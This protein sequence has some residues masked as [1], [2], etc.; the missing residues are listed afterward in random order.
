MQ[1]DKSK[2][3]AMATLVMGIHTSIIY[4]VTSC[5]DPKELWDTLKSQFE[6]NTLANKLFL[7]RQFFTT[8]M[9]EDQRVRDHLKSMKEISDKLAAL[10]AAVPEEEKVV[11]LLISLPKSY[12]TLVT[13]LE[14][15]GD[16]VTLAFVEQALVTEEQKRGV[17]KAA[18]KDVGD[19]ALRA[20]KGRKPFKFRCYKCRKEGHKAAECHG[21]SSRPQEQRRSAFD[22]KAADDEEENGSHMFM[23][24]TG[25]M[26][27]ENNHTWILDSGAS[28]HMT[29][30]RKLLR[31]YHQ[32][33]VPQ[34]VRLGDGRTVEA[35]G[36]GHVRITV[37]TGQ[38]KQLTTEMS[39]VLYVP[40]LACNLFSVRAVTQKGLVVQFG[41]T[42]CWIKTSSGK[43]IGKGRLDNRMYQLS[44]KCEATDAEGDQAQPAVEGPSLTLWHQ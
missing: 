42:C 6:R 35:Y 36:S 17:E 3:K 21:K 22:A 27:G 38:G 30:D 14:A 2:Q 44:C 41:H 25:Q 9:S 24:T 16:D 4:M 32:F 7:K 11:A 12:D 26:T 20:E 1:F 33:D 19:S 10:G 39:I 18:E 8:K 29:S 13:A 23:M 34:L 5:D 15:K 40:K 43:V 28:R 31:Q 37:E